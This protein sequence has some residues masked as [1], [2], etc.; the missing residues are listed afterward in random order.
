MRRRE[1]IAALGSAAAWPLVARAQQPGR[2]YHLSLFVPF[3]RDVPGYKAFF[4]ELRLNGYVEGRNLTVT[5]DG[6][7]VNNN[8]LAA[9]AAA[10]VTTA[11]DAIFSGP[12]PFTSAVQAATHTIPIV[13]LSGNL[14]AAGLVA[15]LAHPGGNTTGVSMFAPELDGKRQDLLIEAVPGAHRMAALADSTMSQS[16]PRHFD[17]LKAAAR[18]RGFELSI[19]SVSKPDD[20]VP[21]IN[22][23]KASGAEALNFLATPLFFSNRRIII[24]QVAAARLPAIYQWPEMAEDGGLMAY[25]ASFSHIYRQA[26]KFVIKV[27]R[28]ENPGDIPAEQPTNFELI[29]N[30][31]T[32]QAIG[33][34][35]PAGLSLRAD[36]IIE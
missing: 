18:L 33:H 14:V 26:A 23:A 8:E 4:D 11:P 31:K 17:E 28:G 34:N 7:D 20:L 16:G 3:R 15:S 2:T 19:F 5:D 35:I 36:K 6:F 21:A 10:V 13:A 22:N 24:N 25:G 27:F 29:I 12:D 30:L 1:F 32:A 9:R